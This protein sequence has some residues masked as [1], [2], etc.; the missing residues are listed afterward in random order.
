MTRWKLALLGFGL[1]VV[2]LAGCKQQLFDRER[3]R[4]YS[5]IQA[6][7]YG[8]PANLDTSVAT[9]IQPGNWNSGAL[10]QTVS[11]PNRQIRYLTLQE[12]ISIALEQGTTGFLSIAANP[13]GGGGQG[14][15]NENVQSGQQGTFSDSMRVL[16]IDPAAA[17]ANIE[18]ALAKFDAHWL[19]ST[20]WGKIDNAPLNILNSFQ[21]GDTFSLSNGLYKPLPTGGVA[22]ITFNLNYQKSVIA[23]G[24]GTVFIN[25]AYRPQLL[26]QFEQPLLQS[27]GVEINQ[28]LSNH[29]GS[30]Q[31]PR[32]RPSGGRVEGILVTRVR[33]EQA[34]A[35]FERN[36]NHM[37]L[38]VETAYWNLWAAY[39]ALYARNE[40]IIDGYN[41]WKNL[42]NRVDAGDS[43]PQDEARVRAQLEGF[44]AQRIQALGQVIE[45]ERQLRLLLGMNDD[46]TR[47]VPFDS[48]T[49]APVKADYF[50]ALNEALTNRPE[51]V[52]ARQDLRVHQFDILVQRNLL[53]PDLRFV[54]SYDMNGVGS[55]L[56][57][58]PLDASGNA[59]NA[60]ISLANDK[61]N[62][63]NFGFQL[64]V[65]LG[66]R[67]AHSALRV[68]RLN[69]LRS[70]AALRDNERKVVWQLRNYY[71]RI[72]EFLVTAVTQQAQYEAAKKQYGI[73]KD[74]TDI[75]TLS[76]N[77]EQIL[78][79]QQTIAAARAAEFQAIAA[80]NTSLAGFEFCKGS[81]MQYDN[82]MISEG[83]LPECAQIRATDHFRERTKALLMRQRP[84]G[85]TGPTGTAQI[86]RDPL[87]DVMPV[88]TDAPPSVM[89]M[90]QG[91]QQVQPSG[92]AYTPNPAQALPAAAI[93]PG[94]TINRWPSPGNELPGFR[95]PQQPAGPVMPAVGPGTP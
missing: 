49:L 42:K 41:L 66:Y 28:L 58:S 84:A 32:F 54:S 56:D 70:Y 95:N 62:T 16:A 43:P 18:A 3:D 36:V 25:P 51:L 64:D 44:R 63:W 11:D 87:A 34:R 47:L 15:G 31:I 21:N 50:G 74:R 13:S 5:R 17:G 33:L 78:N 48:P 61:F 69:L 40:S 45:F 81:I 29:P 37:L 57:G 24:A 73:L 89:Q 71:S 10:P 12:A 67:D 59:K 79:A 91:R 92:P 7:K 94:P 65:P 4:D 77:L 55:R 75:S 6:L 76:Q 1:T 90:M 14:T 9:T 27:Y 53:K 39:G 35:E 23:P 22:G 19:S 8:A 86:E 82:V 20:T 38:N 88:S 52:Q 72:D 2:G 83:A 60:W 30:V 93:P 46:N 68:S 85:E 26:L 80:Y